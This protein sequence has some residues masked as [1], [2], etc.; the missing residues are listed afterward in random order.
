MDLEDEIEPGGFNTTPFETPSL[1][2]PKIAG[3][4]QQTQVDI[5]RERKQTERDILERECR[6]RRCE[7]AGMRN[8]R[9]L[10]EFVSEFSCGGPCSGN[11]LN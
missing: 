4:E 1:D 7:L 5:S 3:V 10:W 6:E 8:D 2:L 9:C 11:Y